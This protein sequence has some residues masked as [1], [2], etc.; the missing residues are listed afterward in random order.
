M[1]ELQR[2][3]IAYYDGYWTPA[4]AAQAEVDRLKAL[5]RKL[6]DEAEGFYELPDMTEEQFERAHERYQAETERIVNGG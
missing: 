5:V 6:R 3:L 2:C 4:D 1:A